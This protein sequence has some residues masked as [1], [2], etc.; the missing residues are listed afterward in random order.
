MNL[1]I[2]F[3]VNVIL[4]VSLFAAEPTGRYKKVIDE[5][6]TL[7]ANYPTVS[8]IFSIGDNDDGVNIYAMRI[9]L[10]PKVMDPKKIGQLVVSTHHGDE[11]AC[12]PFTL[13]LIKQLLKAYTDRQFWRS[14]VAEMEFTVIP[15]LN[16]SGYNA[17]QRAERGQDP[18]RD[19]PNPCLSK[20]GGKLK[21]IR[22][23]MELLS[24]RIYTGSVTVHGYDG[25]LT[26]P[27]GLYTD[28]DHTLD[29]NQYDSIFKKAASLNGYKVG[30]A[31]SIVYPAN[32]C[33]EDFVYWKHGSW[34]LLLEL[35]SGAA[36]DIQ[37]TVPAILKFFDLLDSSPSQKNQFAGN[38]QRN[39]GPDLRL[40]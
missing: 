19:Y 12:P 29:H 31:G 24:T 32:G 38:C 34:S 13:A 3:A 40:E 1:R 27:W 18:N 26:Y 37:A 10:T 20:P 6:K 33:F 5:L 36:S 7:Q 30:T 14:G 17:N 35:R 15:V 39:P 25:S 4:S 28:N 23:L 11:S 8:E 16:I 9:S 21:S 2:L 22:R